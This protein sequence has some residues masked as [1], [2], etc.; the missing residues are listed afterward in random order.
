MDTGLSKDVWEATGQNALVTD[1]V[2]LATKLLASKGTFVTKVFR[3]QDYT[4]VLF[5]H[6][7]L[8]EKVQVDKPQASRSASVEI[9]IVG[10]K[11]KVP[12]KIDPLLLD[13]KY[14]F[15][16]DREGKEDKDD[17]ILN[18]MEEQTNAMEQ[19]K[20]KAKKLLAKRQAKDSVR[21]ALGKQIDAIEDGYTDHEFPRVSSS[22]A[23][24]DEEHQRYGEPLQELFDEAS[25]RFVAKQEGIP[26]LENAPSQEEIVAKWLSQDVFMGADEREDLENGDSDN[27]MQLD[28][29]VEHQKKLK[30]SRKKSKLPTV[31]VS[32]VDDDFEIVPAPHTNSS[33]SSDD[34]DEDDIS[35]KSEILACANTM[36]MKKQREQDD[37][38]RDLREKLDR[39]HSPPRRYSP[40]RD[41][42]ARHVSHGVHAIIIIIIIPSFFLSDTPNSLVDR[43]KEEEAKALLKCNCG[44]ENVD[45]EFNDILAAKNE[46]RLVQN[47]CCYYWHR[48][49]L[50]TCVS[51]AFADKWGR[52]T[53]FL[54]R[55]VQMLIFQIA[56]AALIGAKFGVGGDVTQLPQWFAIVVVICICIY[57]A[58]FA[59]S[60]G[61]LGW[62]YAMSAGQSVNVAVNMFF[63]FLIAQVFLSILCTMKFGLFIF[64]AF[65][66]VLMTVFCYFFMPETKNIPIEDITQVWRDHWFWKRFMND[67]NDPVNAAIKMEQV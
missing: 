39:R 54:E 47:S 25:V 64:F 2:K 48:N 7:P 8:F 65:F 67:P 5:Y 16:G 59:W 42:R 28:M 10:F 12:A 6:R 60:W 24:T 63:T 20:K 50:A 62:L 30:G 57:V 36:L 22:D 55:G 34:S 11:Y 13:V 56:V 3:F 14:L 21:K 26:L 23:D 61:P 66:V 19:K 29:P 15:Q 46:A 53:L 31:K 43:G 49:V 32:K 18:E 17:R 9:Y 33:D 1:S 27:E 45:A 35:S 40:E 58:G 37:R 52:T 41:T 44:V 4:A 51:I 38:G